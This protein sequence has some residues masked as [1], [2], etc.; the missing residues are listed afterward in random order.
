ML[1]RMQKLKQGFLQSPPRVIVSGFALII[2]IGTLLLSQ[3][4]ATVQGQGTRWIDALF[5]ATSATCVTGLVVVDT[6]THY[7]A[8]GQVILMLLIQIGGLGFMTMATLFALILRKRI[9]LKERLLLQEAMN[10]TSI[11]GIVRLIRNVLR[12]SLVIEAV[13]ALLYTIRFR[14]ICR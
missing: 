4:F 6:G 9:S 12:Y 10:Q 5:T 11:E 14:S 1:A 3:P 8:L 2:V 13:G 7:S